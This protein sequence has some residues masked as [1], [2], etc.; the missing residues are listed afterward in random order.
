M[1]K[2]YDE[3]I[4][5]KSR[6]AE[7]V[8]FD[9]L[10]FVT[11]LWE[12]QKKIV[13]LAVKKGRYALFEDCG[14]GKTIQQ[15][16]WA[17]QVH[18]YTGESV[19]VGCPLAVAKQTV[20]EGSK[21][22]VCV[23]QI[24]HSDEVTSPGIYITNRD[25]LKDMDPSKF[26]G[27]VLDESSCLK[28]FTGKNRR[29]ITNVFG[30]C[31]FL[32][33]CSA[34]PAPND[35]TEL[36]QHAEFLGI[37]K[38]SEMLAQYF[39]NDTHDTGTWRI[40]KHAEESFWKWVS[41]WAACI[42]KPSDIGYSDEGF[43]LPEVKVHRVVVRVDHRGERGSGWLFNSIANP[44][45]TEFHKHQ[46]RTMRE[47]CSAAAEIVNNSN[48]E[49]VVWCEGNDESNLLA[50][51]IR[52]SVEVRGSDSIKMKEDRIEL[53]ST[54]KSR[55]IVTKPSIAGM[56]LNWQHCR[57]E[58]YVGMDYSFE[59]FYQASRRIYR[60]G[61]NREVNRYIVETDADNGVI[62]AVE[63]KSAQHETM[64]TLMK[65]TNENINQSKNIITLNTTI[66][67]EKGESWELFNGDCVR[68]MET[69]ESNS[70]GF[71]IFS[72]PF[73][74]LFTYSSDVQDMG[75]CKNIEEFMV[76]FQ[77]VIDQ[78]KRIIMPGRHV[79]VHCCD[80]LSAKWKDGDIELRDF[81]GL[82]TSAFRKSGF[83]FTSRVTIWKD[84]VVEQ[85]RTKAHGLLYKTLKNDSANSRVGVPEYLLVFRKPGKN[86]VP[87][88]H[89][90]EN[91][92][93]QLWREIASP[94]WMTIDQGDVLNSEFA[95]DNKDEKHICPL[96]KD[97]IRRALTLWSAP[98]DLV[99]SPFTGIGS[100]GY[101]AVLAGRRFVGA[102]LKP[103]YFE[104]ACGFL[105]DADASKT[106]LFTA[107]KMN[108]KTL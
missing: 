95:R 12:W 17:S 65:F 87:I 59:K 13:A 64:K 56:G 60:F 85:E 41:S 102:E 96:Q 45:S 27:F 18:R 57:N 28:S 19:L 53:F 5:S 29:L 1:Q 32:L 80:L 22:G 40:K 6:M 35:F 91:F 70:I 104:A 94:V 106:D 92:P 39:I 36:G 81:S 7:E 79:A 8:G 67:S 4:Q 97:V 51:L 103:S 11:P 108:P 73:A 88:K 69:L 100:E 86:T 34:T 75:N 77:F 49:F 20:A 16:E 72:P 76:Q 74:D 43:N 31:R 68:V 3:L 44:S 62:R 52:D 89:N 24:K 82:L 93:L 50:E 30:K 10:P 38:P 84:P 37:C 66:K 71:S 105:R 63:N 42:S 26:I 21:F 61:Q 99:L 2:T 33:A 78:L 54:G 107:A 101:C 46:R 90:E 55:V 58:I 23:T 47:R 98:G 25:R 15:L 83:L 14:L 48:E 9:A